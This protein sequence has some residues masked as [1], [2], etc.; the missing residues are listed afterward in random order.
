MCIHVF[1]NMTLSATDVYTRFHKKKFFLYFG[2]LRSST[3][4][5]HETTAGLSRSTL[6]MAA[7]ML[8]PSSPI[9]RSLHSKQ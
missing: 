8:P 9:P 3:T 7:I 4:F 6:K 1:V 2:P 5:Q